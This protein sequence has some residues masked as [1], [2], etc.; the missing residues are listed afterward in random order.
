MA[1]ATILPNGINQSPKLI[2]IRTV[3]FVSYIA[4]PLVN[5]A[6][7][8]STAKYEF[9]TKSKSQFIIYDKKW[10]TNTNFTLLVSSNTKREELA[11]GSIRVNHT[12]VKLL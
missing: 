4:V 5:L 1:A 10:S 9:S 6:L 11:D 3:H 8:P 7:I 12:S 2:S